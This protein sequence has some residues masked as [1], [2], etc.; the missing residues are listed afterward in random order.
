MIRQALYFL[1]LFLSFGVNAQN[2]SFDTYF[3]DNTLNILCYH[4]GRKALEY[5]IIDQTYITKKWAGSKTN[6]L[7]NS[8]LGAHRIEVY[9]NNSNTLIYSHNYCSLFEEWQTT[10][11]AKNTCGN[12][13]EVL[14]I[15]LPKEDVDIVFFSRDSLGNWNKIVKQKI[16]VKNAVFKT[17]NYKLHEPYKLNVSP[18]DISKKLDI[19]IVPAGYTQK[20]SLKMIS[21]MKLFSDFFFSKP[22]FSEAKDKINIWGQCYFSEQIGIAGLDSTILPN[23]FLGVSYN[24]FNSPRYIMTP[25]LFNLHEILINVPYEQFVIM[26]NSETYGGGGIFNFYATSY[27]NPKNGFVLI[28]EFGH[29]FAGLGDEYSENDNDVEGATQNIEP[30]QKNV[31]S[32][33]DFSKKWK[34]MMDA[35]TPIPTPITKE[36]ENKV[37]VFEG[38]A[39]VN[40]G[41]YRP[42]QNCLMRSDKPFCPVCTK[43]INKMLDFYTE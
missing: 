12:F 42:S 7:D 35:S 11:E 29:S 28:H 4:S 31:T 2:P 40:K 10:S 1:F 34:D 20:D 33:K 36:F 6:L 26:C 24:T 32:L 38:A 5:Y 8:N 30:W 15:P 37:G 18:E 3:E 9:A 23:S 19:V 14:R 13:E 25:N 39:Y 21:D 43:E 16:E 17:L 27:V 22:P 41:L